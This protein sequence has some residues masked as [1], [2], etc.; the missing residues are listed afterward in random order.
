MS[1]N[2]LK[3]FGNSMFGP[4]KNCCE[5]CGNESNTR[6]WVGGVCKYCQKPKELVITKAWLKWLVLFTFLIAIVETIINFAT[7]SIYIRL[8]KTT[9][10]QRLLKYTVER[11]QRKF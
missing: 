10:S 11:E 9:L 5:I 6:D 7:L 1:Q 8:M 3:H 4:E 2:E